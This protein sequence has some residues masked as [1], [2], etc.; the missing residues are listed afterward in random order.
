LPACAGSPH[1]SPL[2]AGRKELVVEDQSNVQEAVEVVIEP[3]TA[4]PTKVRKSIP[5]R[6]GAAGKA[7]IVYLGTGSIGAALVAY[8][9]FRAAGC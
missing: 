9:I 4:E 7:L 6:V 8:L 1:A 5:Q 2:W 3:K